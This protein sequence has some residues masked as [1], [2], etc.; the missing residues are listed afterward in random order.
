MCIVCVCGVCVWCVCVLLHVYY[1]VFVCA[2]II[3]LCLHVTVHNIIDLLELANLWSKLT[4][5]DGDDEVYYNNYTGRYHT[6]QLS[7]CYISSV[8]GV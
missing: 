1:C 2:H 5:V 7:L 8:V 4:N 3:V 6:I